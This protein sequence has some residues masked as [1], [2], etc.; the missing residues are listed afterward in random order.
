MSNTQ[1]PNIH[2][3][4]CGKSQDDV[5]KMIAGSD[6]YICNECIELS[7]RILEEEL[8]EEQDSKCLKLKHLKK[9]LTI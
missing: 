7:T 5:K 6:V 9:C 1:N 3:S 2:C 4:F 8:R